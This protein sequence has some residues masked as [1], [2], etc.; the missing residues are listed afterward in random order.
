MLG[1]KTNVSYAV[2]MFPEDELDHILADARARGLGRTPCVAPVLCLVSSAAPAMLDAIDFAAE[3]AVRRQATCRGSGLVI[4]SAGWF[5]ATYQ[6][7][8]EGL[9]GVAM[10]NIGAHDPISLIRSAVADR[11]DAIGIRPVVESYAMGVAAAGVAAVR[12]WR[13]EIVV[14]PARATHASLLSTW[15]RHGLERALRRRS[16]A[17]VVAAGCDA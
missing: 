2:R 17:I 5:Q 7:S 10:P 11:S 12:K 4:V 15:R 13:S 16:E 9:S 3:I 14:V 1:A 6:Q 8:I